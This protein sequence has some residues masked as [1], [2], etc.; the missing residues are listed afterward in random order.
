[1][2]R[3]KLALTVVLALAG[4][5]VLALVGSIIILQSGWFREKVRETVIATVENATGGRAEI[6]AFAFDWSDMRADVRQFV[7]HGTEPA[8]KPPLVRASS[9]AVGL[10]ILSVLR[11]QVDVRYLNIQDP[12]IYLIIYPDGRTNIPEPKVKHRS[13]RTAMDTL[14][15]LAVGQFNIQNGIFEMEARSSFPFNLRGRNLGAKFV[16]DLIGRRYQGDLSIQ[17]LE[18]QW[19]GQLQAPLGV[20]MAVTLERDRIT[21]SNARLTFGDSRVDFSGTLEDLISPRISVRYEARA[22]APDI[23]RMFR[24]PGLTGGTGQLAGSAEWSQASQYSVTGNLQISGA[25]FRQPPWRFRN[26]KAEGALS[27]DPAGARLG[28]LRFSGESLNDGHRFPLEGRAAELTLRGDE[29]NARDLAIQA[30]GGNFTGGGRIRAWNRFDVRGDLRNLDARR[31]VAVY[32]REPLPWNSLVSG[33]VAIEGSA[34]RQ[35]DLRVSANLVVAPAPQSPPVHGQLAVMYDQSSGILELG[36]STITLPASRVDLT[37]AVGR[38]LR[39]HLET[40]NV[41][42]FLAALGENATSIPLNLENGSAVFDGTVTGQIEK[43]QIAGHLAL[44]RFAYAGKSFDSLQSDVTASPDSVHLQN[45]I[46]ARGTGRGQFQASLGLQDWKP[47]D[48]SA[49]AGNGSLRNAA[50]ADLLALFNQK[51]VAVTGTL[52]GSG[53]VSGTLGNPQASAD[54]EVVKG[55]IRDEPF[56]RFSAHLT[57]GARTLQLSQGQVTAG[58]KQVQVSADFDHPLKVFDT[59][60]LRFQ[61]HSNV[62]PLGQIQTLARPRPGLQGTAQLT[63]TGQ[64]DLAP[65]RNGGTDLRLTELQA[66]LTAR[67]LQLTGQPLGDAHLTATSQGPVLRAHLDSTFANSTIR[68]DG[69]W[70]MEADYPG[71]AT[72]AFSKVDLTGL[73]QWISP[74]PSS[75]A[76]PFTGFAEGEFHINGPALKPELLKADLRIPNLEIRPASGPAS[77]VL[78]NSGPIVATAANSVITIEHAELTGRS[79]DV[80]IGGKISLTQKNPLDVR[81]TGN[82][83]L[84]VLQTFNPD[85]NASGTVKMEASLRGS[86]ATPQVNGRLDLNDGAMNYGMLPNGITNA[87]GVILFTGDR[88]TIQKLE[89]NTGGGTIQLSGFAGYD[90]DGTIFGLHATAQQVRVRY[91]EG[92]STV[93]DASLDLTGSQERSTLAG[94]ITIRRAG[95]NLESDIGNLLA[96][97]AEPVRTPAGRGGFLAGINYDIQ[98]ETAPDIEFESTLTQDIQADAN[99]RLRGTTANPALLGR[100][101]I[102]QGQLNFFG[103]KY[104]INQGSVS[105]FNPVKIEP[106]INVDLETRARGIDITLTVSGPMN[107]LTLTPRSDP[108]LQFNEIISLLTTGVAPSSDVTRLGQQAPAAQPI[109]QSAA[110]ALL[111]QVI[112]NP[113]SGRLQRFFGISKLRINPTLDP[114]LANGVQYNPQARLTIEQQISP[115]ITFTYIT[116]I[117]NANPQIVSMEWSVSKQWSVVAQREENG[118]LGLDFYLKKRFR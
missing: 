31:A 81:V 23:N 21:A 51:T 10:K 55:T 37:G 27:V 108:P 73:R 65:G 3:P 88:A 107:K 58:G 44:T 11:Q 91:P 101:N 76:L 19:N 6:G 89:G 33:S 38:Q 112:A 56:D 41:N 68:G 93:A 39:V 1:M 79:T 17:P 70:R 87:S 16:Y 96:K 35:K 80:T 61:I 43:P 12:H 78:K 15:N 20:Q 47:V 5:V 34:R 71:S 52:S 25:E 92:V 104:T 110:T 99:L 86:P 97:S 98:I 50:V 60:R 67:G 49:L 72:V 75:G 82:V 77:I 114:A 103:T 85:V 30:L 64:M 118:L 109:Q 69:E 40:R 29:L 94:N 18:V 95:I 4:L 116:N 117:S 90:E 105:F 22:T 36:R 14:V 53:Q 113:L 2:S 32:S 28:G 115:N 102:T 24:V 66:D 63:A 111:G 7:L 46:L 106:I 8:G 48:A 9:V 57:G 84:A 42:D 100:I 54:I 59:G 62:L 13:E 74:S 26:V 83:D 45:A